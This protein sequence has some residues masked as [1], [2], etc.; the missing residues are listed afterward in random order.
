MCHCNVDI[1]V[2]CGS[3]GADSSAGNQLNSQLMPA[4]LWLKRLVLELATEPPLYSLRFPT[5]GNPSMLVKQA[6]L[7][8]APGKAACRI[9]R[10]TVGTL[11]L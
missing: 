9:A 10:A 5:Q 6:F 4:F 1:P 3:G 8:C 7:Q 11:S 2:T